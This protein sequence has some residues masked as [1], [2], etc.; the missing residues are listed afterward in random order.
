VH[1]VL[2]LGL[3]EEVDRGALAGLLV[4]ENVDDGGGVLVDWSNDRRRRFRDGFGLEGSNKMSDIW[5][6]RPVLSVYR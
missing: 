2:A 3:E 1:A 6:G 4:L 5:W